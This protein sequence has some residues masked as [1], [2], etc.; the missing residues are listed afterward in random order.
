MMRKISKYVLW[1]IGTLLLLTLAQNV[2]AQSGGGYSLGWSSI[3]SGSGVSTGGEFT[4]RGTTG[5]ADA[6]TL[7]G[8]VYTL[9][10]GFW[11]QPVSSSVMNSL[12]DAAPPRNY[13]IIRQVTLTWNRVSSATAYQ[14]E[15]SRNSTFTDIV[16]TSPEIDASTLFLATNWPNNGTYYWHVHAKNSAGKWSAWSAYDSFVVNAP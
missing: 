2:G 5:Q 6:G 14:V 9:A 11:G 12:P 7:S 15:V 4:L 1:I 3:D 10:G 16:Y 8:G 13:F